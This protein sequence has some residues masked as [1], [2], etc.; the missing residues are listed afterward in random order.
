MDRLVRSACEA[1]ACLLELLHSVGVRGKHGKRHREACHGR[2]GAS[3]VH[4]CNVGHSA[5]VLLLIAHGV[6]EGAA[7]ACPEC[8]RAVRELTSID[9]GDDFCMASLQ[10]STRPLQGA[11]IALSTANLRSRSA[12][13]H[14]HA[15]TMARAQR[16]TRRRAPHGL[17]W[18][19]CAPRR[20]KSHHPTTCA[21]L[22]SSDGIGPLAGEGALSRVDT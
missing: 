15:Y 4:E 1:E 9:L 3:R 8:A 21:M 10:L 20:G 5:L 22:A 6:W 16:M 19:P 13:G 18:C 17:Y 11:V 12:T 7:Q 2:L 14:R